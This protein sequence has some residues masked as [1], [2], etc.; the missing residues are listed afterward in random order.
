M[1]HSFRRK[2]HASKRLKERAGPS[3]DFDAFRKMVLD[4]REFEFVVKAGGG[5][6]LC[7]AEYEGK[8]VYFIMKHGSGGRSREIATVLTKAMAT[9]SF[10]K[11][12][13]HITH[14]H[15]EMLKRARETAGRNRRLES[16]NSNLLE[17]K[18]DLQRKISQMANERHRLKELIDGI[19][20]WFSL[21]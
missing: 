13:V 15:L 5:S 2:R 20:V 17:E 18:K 19:R 1:G 4:D 8:D 3:V 6:D 11:A 10:P 12:F 7:Y 9:E 21:K 14:P 16:L